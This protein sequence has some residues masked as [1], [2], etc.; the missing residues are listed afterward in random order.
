MSFDSCRGSLIAAFICFAVAIALPLRYGSNENRVLAAA[1][2][3]TWSGQIAPVLYNNCTTCHHPGGAGP[4]SL[5]TYEDA[6][7]WAPQILTVTQSRY[8]PPWLPAPGYG[9]FADSRRL[10]DR[11]LA[12]IKSWVAAGMPKGDSAMAPP[13][14]HYSATWTLGKPDL[15]LTVEQPFTLP[16]GGEDVFRNFILPYP[17]KE[18]HYVRAME[19]LP[20][21]PEIVHHA[22]VLIDRTAEYRRE[23][24]QDWRRG[25]P[26]MELVVDAGKSFDPDGHFLFWKPDT[27]GL[28]EPAGMPWR[29][30]PGNDLILNMHLKPSG[31]AETIKA[32]I[33]LYFT[34][35]PPSQFPMLLQLDRDD[36]LDIPAGDSAFTL[37]DEMTLPVDVHLLGIYPHAHYLG[38]DMQAWAILPDKKKVWLI[39][40]RGW[41]ID[42]QSVYRY[43]TPLFLPK[44]TTLHMRY[45]YDNSSKN[46]H[47]PHNPPVRV[48]AGNRSEDEMAH[49]WLQ[50]LPVKTGDGS[51]PRLMLEEAWMRARLR[52]SPDDYVSLYNLGAA[53]SGEGKEHDAEGVFEAIVRDKPDDGRAWNA[54]GTATESAGDWQKA[55]EVYAK[56]VGVDA[57]NCDARFNLAQLDLKH[58]RDADAEG[59]FRALIASCGDDVDARGGLGLV[60]LGDRHYEAAQEEFLRALSLGPANAQ[61]ADLREHLAFAYL[62]TGK[63]NDGLVQLREAVKLAP[64]DASAH[65]L[66]AQVLSQ[67]DQLQEA[68]AEQET[69]LRLHANDADGW[70]NL[71]VFEARSGDVESARRDFQKAQSIDPENEQAKAN[72]ARLSQQP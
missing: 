1:A 20:G 37:E 69:A 44:G 23:H 31:K 9:D 41:D 70:N 8:M 36:A 62:Q 61:A 5:L 40:I 6:R 55:R 53:L 54:L 18:T 14:P 30:D 15:I 11:D 25:V 21:V 32:Q 68:I 19:I 47:N 43:K 49:L 64:D 13:Q 38:K 33:G 24:P 16:A 12:L 28:V 46:P 2:P 57:E 26:G 66:L 3:A 52:R 22:N 58:D 56:A 65:A 39:W 48:R 71:G 60:L 59:E 72:L 51:D 63:V 35:T 17:L 42:R 7:R 10:S 4:F 67:A 27:P 50:V 34:D 29:L 45:V